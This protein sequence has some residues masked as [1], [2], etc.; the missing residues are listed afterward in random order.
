M[1][2]PDKNDFDEWKENHVTRWIFSEVKRAI[3][4][5]QQDIGN[6]NTLDSR[7]IEKTALVT[8]GMVGFLDGLREL[9]K[10]EIKEESE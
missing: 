2:K 7:S 1:N 10:I 8:A 3:D 4:E 6:G 5:T 9:Y